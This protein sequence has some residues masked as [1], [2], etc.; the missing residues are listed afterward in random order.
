MQSQSSRPPSGQLL[1]KTFVPKGAMPSI[2]SY[3]RW[4]RQFGPHV[5]SLPKIEDVGLKIVRQTNLK[6]SDYLRVFRSIGDPWLWYS[7][8]QG[9]EDK[10]QQE[11]GN[12][13]VTIFFGFVEGE[14]EPIALL[15]VE[16]SQEKEADS[17]GF[18]KEATANDTSQSMEICF[19][20][21]K[22]E[23]E[24][25]RIGPAI[26]RFAL[27]FFLN[28]SGVDRLH[29]NTCTQDSPRALPFYRKMGFDVERQCVEIVPDPRAT[30]LIDREYAPHIP[31]LL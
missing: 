18:V 25:K 13:A 14:E 2:V 4:N 27:E 10:I 21:L 6:P 5:N 31:L 19:L 8:L 22:R 30:G 17:A 9:S 28:E 7:R 23:Y 16:V 11:L 26:M 24:G 29:L 12:S 1:P 3:L 20:G 15:Q